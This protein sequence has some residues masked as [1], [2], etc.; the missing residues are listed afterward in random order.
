VATLASWWI[1]Q[2]ILSNSELPLGLSSPR[3]G[4]LM[5]IDR[6]TLRALA[7]ASQVGISIAAS[8]GVGVLAGL[9]LD[10]HL[11]TRPILLLLGATAGLLF[12][13]YIIRDL[14]NFKRDEDEEEDD[15]LGN[16]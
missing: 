7:L 8:I 14:A 1:S 12:A 11:G 2:L 15:K 5:K 10:N 13:G 4:L 16:H 6:G 9:W 3:I